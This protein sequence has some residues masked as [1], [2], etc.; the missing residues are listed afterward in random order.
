MWTTRLLILGLVRWLQP[1]HGYMVKRELMSW[2][3]Q[4]W[5][6][7]R[8]G[9]IYHALKRLAADDCLEVVSTEQVDGRP[10]RT[11]YRITA[12]GE[13]E[14]HST[15]REKLWGM[16]FTVD[17]FW[18]AWSFF[19]TLTPREG[20]AMLRNRASLLRETHTEVAKFLEVAQSG[21]PARET[22]LP[23]HVRES[24]VFKQE[25][26]E[27]NIRWCERLAKRADAGELNFGDA[28]DLDEAAARHWRDHIENL[29]GQGRRKDGGDQED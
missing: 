10:A 19:P 23:E 9:S 4:D 6:K 22:F 18:V 26:L 8:T 1:V 25:T 20:A 11:S 17:P 15:L 12:K 5:A 21:N 3:V 24:L 13:K 29:D 7:I 27:L 28:V 14:F 2:G 16:E